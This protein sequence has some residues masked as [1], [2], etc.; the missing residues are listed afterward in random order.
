MLLSGVCLV[1][2]GP[3][4]PSVC[5]GCK[6]NATISDLVTILVDFL[7]SKFFLKHCAV[8]SVYFFTP[9]AVFPFLLQRSMPE[10]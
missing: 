5:Q 7:F 10:A 9:G 4:S 3:P 2:N 1:G 6:R 8:L